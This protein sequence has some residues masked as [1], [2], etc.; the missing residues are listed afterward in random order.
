MMANTRTPAEAH[1]PDESAET[2]A[3]RARGI[4]ATYVR[5][6]A[7][8]DASASQDQGKTKLGE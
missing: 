5:D 7:A 2:D 4:A 8:A 6:K 3:S 1:N